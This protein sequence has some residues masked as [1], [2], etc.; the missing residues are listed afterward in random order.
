MSKN[1]H[2]MPDLNMIIIKRGQPQEEHPHGG[3]W[4]V[5]FADFMTAMMAFFLV[6]WIVNS[7]N[8]ETRSSVARYFNPIRISDTTPA[9]K[10]LKDPKEVDFDAASGDEKA[11]AKVE[12]GS[13]SDGQG[14]ALV[15]AGAHPMLG[16]AQGTSN[17]VNASAASSVAASLI[18]PSL[19]RDPFLLLD[20]IAAR[21]VGLPAVN[22]LIFASAIDGTGD[23]AQAFRDPF[24]PM[25]PVLPVKPSQSSTRSDQRNAAKEQ[26]RPGVTQAMTVSVE[27]RESKDHEGQISQAFFT[28]DKRDLS[29]QKAMAEAASL[30]ES[31][32]RAL[33]E[34]GLVQG[35]RLDVRA[36]DDGIL[37]SLTDDLDFGM[38]AVGSAEPQP[39]FVRAM[40]KIGS[41]LSAE[42][43]NFILRGHTDARPYRSR[44]YD[45][46]RL[47]SARAQMTAYMLMRGKLDEKR[48]ERVEGHADRSLRNTS[49]PLAAENRRIEILLRR[50]Q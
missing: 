17:Q 43:G 48:I 45:N 13:P 6:L 38:F 8:K 20:E 15:G 25:A 23:G 30:R 47:S 5:A 26:L 12:S 50:P 14:G 10:G 41:L 31:I 40:E 16:N 39:R 24:A 28:D 33:R 46:W 42:A 4:K 3:A 21:A 49:D 9:R 44:A 37:I 32:S 19:A 35:P 1:E 34:A 11:K 29:L 2:E 22:D 27:Q 7:T 36:I 18:D